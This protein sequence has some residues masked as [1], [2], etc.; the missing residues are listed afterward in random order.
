MRIRERNLCN[1]R[2][3]QNLGKNGAD[4][5]LFN[6]VVA[7]SIA[8]DQS[9][10]QPALVF[11]NLIGNDVCNSPPTIDVMTTPK[12]M[13]TNTLKTMHYLDTVLT[14]GSH[15]VIVPLADGRVLYDSLKNRYHPI[16]QLN[17]DLTYAQFYDFFNCLEISPCWGWM[18]SNETVRDETTKRAMQLNQQLKRVSEMKFKNFDIHYIDNPFIKIIKVCSNIF[19]FLKSTCYSKQCLV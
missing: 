2:D 4:S 1:H 11:Y 17:K 16:G 5:F 19:S 3:F 6:S 10:D 12:E 15:I 18:N 13:Y 8:R 7:P 9:R 14:A